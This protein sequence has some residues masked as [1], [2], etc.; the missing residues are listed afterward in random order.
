M[1]VSHPFIFEKL[2]VPC[3]FASCKNKKMFVS[4]LEYQ[5]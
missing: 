4:W 5:F 2:F 1:K 3:A